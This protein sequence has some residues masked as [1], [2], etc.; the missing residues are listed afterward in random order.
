MT[1]LDT[2]GDGHID[3]T[4]F[5]VAIRVSLLFITLEKLGVRIQIKRQEEYLAFPFQKAIKRLLAT[6]S[7]STK[8]SFG[9]YKLLTLTIF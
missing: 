8:T 2:N 9:V 5:L 7:I 1:L 3:M 6:A 4:E